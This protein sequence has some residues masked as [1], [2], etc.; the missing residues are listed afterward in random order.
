MT[1]SLTQ[2]PLQ[3]V[4]GDSV[5]WVRSIPDYPANDGWTL[6]YVLLSQGKAPIT[7]DSTASG[8]DHHVILPAT[9]TTGW[10]SAEYRWT[11]FVTKGS[12]R[13]TLT[14]GLVT[15]APDPTQADVSFDPRTDNQKIL[16]GIT[17]VLAGE[18]TNPLAKYKIGGRE[19]REVERHSR[20]ELLKLQTIY[21]QRVAVENGQAP[22]VGSIPIGFISDFGI[23]GG[24]FY[25]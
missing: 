12:E 24:V 4:A 23:P 11:A 9:T 2:E 21:K 20:M 15:I 1:S 6:H 14:S 19:G 3:I 17:A 25:E 10:S 13:K 8:S 22:F 16:A 18:L 5:D 7:I